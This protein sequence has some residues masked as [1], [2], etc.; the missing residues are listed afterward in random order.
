MSEVIVSKSHFFLAD[1]IKNQKKKEFVLIKTV[2]LMI[3]QNVIL[4][5]IFYFP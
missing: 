4:S 5:F 3:F 2:A 1:V